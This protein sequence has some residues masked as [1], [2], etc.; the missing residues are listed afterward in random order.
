LKCTPNQKTKDPQRK[1][2]LQKKQDGRTDLLPHGI[3]GLTHG[4]THSFISKGK[5]ERK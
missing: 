4:K 1:T 3:D 2:D 5:G